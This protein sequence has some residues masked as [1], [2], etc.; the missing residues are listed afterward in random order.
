MKL[1]LQKAF[2]FLLGG[3]R[4]YYLS[5]TSR[6]ATRAW[7]FKYFK[8]S[9]PLSNNNRIGLRPNACRF[10]G[11]KAIISNRN[12]YSI[13]SAWYLSIQFT[14]EIDYLINVIDQQNL[15]QFRIWK[16]HSLL[17]WKLCL[18]LARLAG[19]EPATYRFVAGHSIH[20]ATSAWSRSTCF[21]ILA[22]WGYIVN[23]FQTIVIKIFFCLRGL[24]LWQAA[25]RT[26]CASWYNKKAKRFR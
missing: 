19:F 20:W 12:K 26:Y 21:I 2:V 8:K 24:D 18:L 11:N 9:C 17:L 10:F 15:Y 1:F 16:R 4:I 23:P 13:V 3:M 5:Q 25:Q 7:R 6:F 14:L 22:R